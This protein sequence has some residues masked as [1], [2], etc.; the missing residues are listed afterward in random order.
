L[1][2]KTGHSK[3]PG[4]SSENGPTRAKTDLAHAIGSALVMK[5]ICR[6]HAR[7]MTTA[8]MRAF[9]LHRLQACKTGHDRE[10]VAGNS[11]AILSNHYQ[12]GRQV[13]TASPDYDSHATHWPLRRTLAHE[14]LFTG[15]SSSMNWRVASTRKR[16]WNTATRYLANP[17]GNGTNSPCVNLAAD[18]TAVGPGEPT[19]CARRNHALGI[20][21]RVENVSCRLMF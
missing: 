15:K 10:G 12:G 8:G 18:G 20:R 1:S 21:P 3:G 11:T 9:L 2:T 16:S 4:N 13:E 6:P 14:H 7:G 19:P 17:H 5:F